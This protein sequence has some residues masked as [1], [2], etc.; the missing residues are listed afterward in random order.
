MPKKDVGKN[1]KGKKNTTK[2]YST[3]N[4]YKNNN[5]QK[6]E[7]IKEVEVEE[8]KNVVKKE[9]G[10][11]DLRNNAPFIVASCFCII[12]LIA[13]I[14][15][16]FIKRITKVKNGNEVIATLKGKTITAQNLYQELKEE[17]GTSALINIIDDYIANKEVKI[18]K[19]DKDYVQEVVDYY[20]QYAEYYNTDLK[21]F[22]ANYVGLSNIST[23]EEFYDYVLNDYKKTLAV[24]QL[25]A[26]Q[27]SEKDLKKYYE[28]NYTDKLTVR[29]ILIE[30]DS[31]AEDQEAAEKE[32]LEK[33]KKL[34]KKLDDTDSK[35]LEDKITELAKDNSDDTG[36]YAD[37]G[38]LKDFSKKDVVEEF[39]NASEK[40]K[41]GEYTKEP[42]KTTY[43][44]HIIYKVGSKAK[45]K[46][47]DVKE[48]VKKEYA[49]NELANDS[50][51]QVTKWDELRKQYKL[52]IK[53]DEVKA[54][55]KKTIKDATKSDD[56]E[57]TEEKTDS[58]EK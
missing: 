49:D 44:Y 46:Y 28:E 13:L 17:N 29:H 34:I 42:I 2:P 52:S 53:D 50:S 12:L 23:E 26:D 27:A 10:D 54:A 21:T 9:K 47:K 19:D 11:M 56:K 6:K 20:K 36:T 57:E 1:S 24:K 32:A 43:G 30:V 40:L 16:L 8:V 31:E 25:I 22:L 48:Q 4:N 58:S 55:Y 15:A 51:L 14:L 38:L 3:K 5:K 18:T 33:A 41:K 45:E 7:V 35:K 37:G 39:W